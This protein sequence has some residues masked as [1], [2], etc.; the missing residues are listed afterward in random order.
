VVLQLSAPA[1]DERVLICAPFGRDADAILELL[2]KSGYTARACVG[3]H[4][5]ADELEIS[6]GAV[7]IT[8]EALRTGR[9]RFAE[10]LEAQAAWSEVPILLLTAPRMRSTSWPTPQPAVD[11]PKAATNVVILERP[12]GSVPLVTAVASAIRARKKQYDIRDN[13]E[14]KARAA[15]ELDMQVKTR[16]QELESAL[17]RLKQEVAERQKTE[18]QLRQA[19]KMEAVGQ[20]TGGIAHDFNNMLTGVIGSIDIIKRRI[21]AGRLED[22]D[23]FMEAASQSA[24]R[25]ANLTQ[26]LLAF[27]RRQTL[28]SK[29]LDINALLGSLQDLIV[30][31][32]SELVTVK[33]V[34]ASKRI[35]AIAD[36]NQLESAIL[37]LA[38][39]ARD[40][41][42]DGGT[43]T[44]EARE[45]SLEDG[46]IATAK[47]GVY[48]LV[49]VSDS[50]VG[51]SPDVVA[52]VFDPFFTTKP[53]GQGTGLG[54][55]MV[56]G[57]AR[58][59]GGYVNID[60]TPG[61]GTTV[62]I[63]LPAAKELEAAEMKLEAES[64]V[65]GNG[66][67]VLVVEDDTSVRQLIR[68][69]LA[70]LGYL[71]IEAA[72]PNLAIPIL[73]SRKTIDLMV[74]DVG[75][76]G[77]SGRQLAEIARQHRPQLPILFVTGYAENAAIRSHFL[78]T[79]MSMI[80]K[81]FALN[82][83][84]QKIHTMI[85]ERPA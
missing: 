68:E 27:S 20:L 41:M 2:A 81:P 54:L 74:S 38:I 12:V 66:Q 60:S 64:I 18:E 4:Q 7:L 57:F 32:V 13:L 50:G 23:R 75:L 25:A 49:A 36:A 43:L 53:I 63:Y 29:P 76:P 48:V 73:A 39:N 80:A 67:A 33:I 42:P 28:D 46:E 85:G 59:S 65:E 62:Q 70:E 69:V 72:D 10:A 84:A 34:P 9:S 11:L 52:K 79:N 55:S 26:R 17:E 56:Y 82:E 83:L 37:N 61:A 30:R 3:L 58:Q 78:G 44:V 15:D 35:F 45:V 24:Q 77:M 51:M 31:T 40:A 5:L 8:E 1:D 14:A 6:A 16:T 47:P 71:A 21:D 22:I 19:Q